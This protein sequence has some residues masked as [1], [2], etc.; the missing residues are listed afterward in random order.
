MP[1]GRRAAFAAVPET[2]PAIDRGAKTAKDYI[3]DAVDDALTEFIR[4]V[5]KQATTDLRDALIAAEER[6]HDLESDLDMC[7]SELED[8]RQKIE[9]LSRRVEDE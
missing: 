1:Y 6:A 9:E 3:T 8:A 5:V 2:C 7:K 4:D